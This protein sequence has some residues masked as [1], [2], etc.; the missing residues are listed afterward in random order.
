[1][2]IFQAIITIDG[3]NAATDYG[4]SGATDLM[5]ALK[6]VSDVGKRVVDEV[7][8]FAET[9]LQLAERQDEL[10]VAITDKERAVA[11]ESTYKLIYRSVSFGLPVYHSICSILCLSF[12]LSVILSFCHFSL[13]V[14]LPFCHSLFLSCLSF[15]HSLFL[16][17]LSFCH[18]LFLSFSLSFYQ[19]I[20][21]YLYLSLNMFIPVIPV[22]I[23]HSLFN[24]L[25]HFLH[26][27][28]NRSIFR[29]P[30]V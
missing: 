2:S 3:V 28:F 11:E 10:A 29:S 16:P 7:S 30:F 5:A 13:S 12:S 23:C 19:S 24:I 21:L 18:S 8:A 17:F 6:S 4:I 20:C 15:C 14:I 9:V 25:C 26:V 1:M 27:I 22:S